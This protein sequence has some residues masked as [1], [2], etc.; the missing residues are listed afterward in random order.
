MSA[1]LGDFGCGPA[2]VGKT[3]RAVE[4]MRGHSSR[5][6]GFPLQLLTW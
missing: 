5:L 6:I 4:R 2:N 3:G 1:A